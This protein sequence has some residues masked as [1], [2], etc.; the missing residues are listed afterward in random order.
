MCRILSAKFDIL[1][2]Q[3]SK[4]PQRPLVVTTDSRYDVL[5][6]APQEDFRRSC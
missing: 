1:E 6:P 5:Y 2:P 4:E 3:P